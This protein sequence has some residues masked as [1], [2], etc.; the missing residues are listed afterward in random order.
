MPLLIDVSSPA[1]TSTTAR[2][3][4]SGAFTPPESPLLLAAWAGNSPGNLDPPAPTASSSPS[5]TWT[6]DAWDRWGSGS[7]QQNGQAA[8]FTATPSGA[9]G[10]T[11]VSVL[12]G[13]SV[14]SFGSALQVYVII[15]HDA[16]TPTGASGGDRSNSPS[17]ITASYTA[18]IT[19]GQGFMVVS[20][21]NASDTTPWAAAA[22]CTI[23]NKGTVSPE[24]S[25]A[26]LRRTD[27]DGVEGAT[28][29]MGLT[30]LGGAATQLHWA[31]LEIISIEAAAARQAEWTFGQSFQVG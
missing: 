29:S 25:Y 2:T 15:G 13:A 27:P 22:G 20:D 30:G 5:Q 6:Q 24:I 19:G 7:P 11:T 10:S 18:T 28:T 17:S 9:V 1:M 21:W 8:L 14:D 23:V 12:N 16:T 26:V 4:T 31:Y 3:N